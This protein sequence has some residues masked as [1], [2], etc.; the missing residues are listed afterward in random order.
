METSSVPA[1][2]PRIY[3][4]ECGWALEGYQ[5]TNASAVEGTCANCGAEA[6]VVVEAA[7][8][9]P[10]R[11]G[12]TGTK[13]EAIEAPSFPLALPGSNAGA[14]RDDFEPFVL[15]ESFVVH[16]APRGVLGWLLGM[17]VLSLALVV[18]MAFFGL[19]LV[20][21]ATATLLGFGVVRAG[22]TVF[23]GGR[24]G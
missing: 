19:A 1:E 22:R 18:I 7:Q 3:C 23:G 2:R 10:T 14:T 24:R 11:L 21:V 9:P 6:W 8:T 5:Q 4:N 13:I 20:A 15:R 12:F 17:G 16:Q